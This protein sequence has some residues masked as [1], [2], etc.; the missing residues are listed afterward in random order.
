MT[1]RMVENQ[2]YG[3]CDRQ[4]VVG[5]SMIGSAIPN[6][7][8]RD[9][10]RTFAAWHEAVKDAALMGGFYLFINGEKAP[11]VEE[12]VARFAGS[13]MSVE[14]LAQMFVNCEHDY[15]E[16]NKAFYFLVRPSLK[17]AGAHEKDDI[18]YIQTHFQSDGGLRDG[19][20]LYQ[21][22]LSF[23]DKASQEAQSQL[24]LKVATAKL[25]H[26]G[27]NLTQLGTFSK[28]LLRNWADIE[29]NSR[30]APDGF[31]HRLLETLVQ[32]SPLQTQAP[33]G[34]L[35]VLM[36]VRK[37]VL[38]QMQ[39]AMPF[40]SDPDEFIEQMLKFAKLM[41]LS[42][43]GNSILNINGNPANAKKN[44]CTICSSWLCQSNQF[45]G[46]ENCLILHP[47]KRT[48]KFLA[49]LSQ[50][51]KNYLD[52]AD[53][54]AKDNPGIKTL[55]GVTF[56][57]KKS[58]E[59][60]VL[61]NTTNGKQGDQVAFVGHGDDPIISDF[62]LFNSFLQDKG[63]LIPTE[64]AKSVLMAK[65][66]ITSPVILPIFTGETADTTSAVDQ[67][68]KAAKLLSASMP[69][70]RGARLALLRS[71]VRAVNA[72][73]KVKPPCKPECEDI[74][75]WMED[76]QKKSLQTLQAKLS[77]YEK[78]PMITGLVSMAKFLFWILRCIISLCNFTNIQRVLIIVLAVA[79]AKEHYSHSI[80]NFISD[81]LGHS[82]WLQSAYQAIIGK[83]LHKPE[84][85]SLYAKV[86]GVI[87]WMVPGPSIF[88]ALLNGL[89]CCGLIFLY[90]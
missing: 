47:E 40:F 44:D 65:Q 46:K 82:Q 34:N 72:A 73:N 41:G 57:G 30:S 20:G 50:K 70:Q 6:W 28:D 16:L 52:N 21:W 58:D 85:I 12:V 60:D 8:P 4:P 76:E 25:P 43:Q 55:K 31:Y 88:T 14:E 53:Q 51:E 69:E 61:S 87:E 36:E 71:T 19:L 7:N 9:G 89:I 66:D 81:V 37:W 11:T 27:I 1:S 35:A 56:T 84:P 48:D 67:V 75:N 74:V 64:T 49:R 13:D 24:R 22:A 83:Y 5:A 79:Y 17:F 77:W 38:T 32:G 59:K 45:G 90:G 15:N 54:F 2:S 33:Y 26:T 63:I 18:E 23:V 78:R 29:G 10:V 39:P 42:D 62:K 80:N 86:A 3:L 68:K